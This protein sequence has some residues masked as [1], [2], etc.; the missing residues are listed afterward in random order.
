MDSQPATRESDILYDRAR[1]IVPAGVHSNSRHRPPHALYFTQAEGCCLTDVDGRRVTDLVMGN[2]AVILGYRD[3][4][5]TEALRAALDRGLGAGVES[6]LSIEAATAVAALLPDGMQVRFT[7]TGTEAAMHLAHIARARTGRPS[8]AKVEGSYHGWYDPLNVS[9][10]PPADAAGPQAAPASVPGSGGDDMRWAADTLVLPHN[11]ADAAE[12]LLREH[13]G[14]LAAVFVEPVLIDAGYIPCQRDF[15]E[16]LRSVTAELGIMLVFDELLTGARQPGGTVARELGAVDAVMLGKAIANGMPVAALAARP[17]WFEVAL[18]GGPSAF[19]GTF[20][21]HA[22][23]LAA[24]VATLDRLRDGAV[25]R[26][27]AAATNRLRLAFGE[28]AARVGIPAVLNGGGGHFQWYFGRTSVDRYRNLWDLD[29]G[30]GRAFAEA[31]GEDGFFTAP[32]VAAHQ[33]IS[34]AHLTGEVDRL[35]AAFG[36]ALERAARAWDGR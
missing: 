19:V 13:A 16:R 10:L 29:A 18:P 15:L 24:V 8:L 28:A 36:P 7:N 23:G 5:V 6:P 1:H 31:L 4:A 35:C 11:D 22:L 2:G 34:F 9:F 26:D 32:G 3:K 21:G 25:Q 27:L 20:N 33:A 17:E 30:A 12:R 14:R